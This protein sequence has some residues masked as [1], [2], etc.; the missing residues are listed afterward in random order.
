MLRKNK[1]L[2]IATFIVMAFIA[3][4]HGPGL[5]NLSSLE[6]ICNEF[7]IPDLKIGYDTEYMQNM[8]ECFGQEGIQIYENIQVVDMFFPLAF[9]FFMFQLL[10][11][12]NVH[13]PSASLLV[14]AAVTVDYIE[15]LILWKQRINYPE[16]NEGL[17]AIASFATKVKFAIILTIFILFG[18]LIIKKMMKW[19]VTG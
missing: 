2:L 5:P 3:L 19:K 6:K 1:W 15:N 8:F 13:K 7:S 12:V 18:V 11:T 17:I 9:G 10:I 16:L 14:L 4:F